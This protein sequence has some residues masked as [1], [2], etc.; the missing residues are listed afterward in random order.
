MRISVTFLVQVIMLSWLSS[1]DA[2]AQVVPDLNADVSVSSPAFMRDTG[3]VIVVDEGH[4][5]YHKSKE[6]FAP[7]AALL[8]NDGFQVSGKEGHIEASYL[9]GV[10]VLVIANALNLVNDGRWAKPV[11]SA[12]DQTEIDAVKA[13]VQNGGALL[14][15]ADHFPFA[16]A[17]AKIGAAFGFSFING[18]VFHAPTTEASDVF[19]VDSG[20]LQDHPITRG[21]TAA[22]SVSKI[23]TF[24][25]SAF[26]APA[27]A[28]PIIVLPQDYVVLLPD[29]AWEFNDETPR[30]AAEGYFQGSAM[31][32]GN[33][34]IAVFGEAAM[35]TAQISTTNP[36][37]RTGFN[38]PEAAENKKLILNTLRW[39]SGHLP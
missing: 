22:D 31:K 39:L 3:P 19:T 13:W 21:Q 36:N 35:F 2:F 33:G 38:A 32:V 28:A 37:S 10:D 7:F 34:R 26:A 14:L 27:N 20:A 9:S 24:T 23:A 25:G 6:R 4:H 1:I 11:P 8:Q 12:F 17:A 15:I 30:V 29:V 16:G 18:F 5:N